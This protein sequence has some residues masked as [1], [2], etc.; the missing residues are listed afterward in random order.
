MDKLCLLL[1]QQAAADLRSY[2]HDPV[3][4]WFSHELKQRGKFPQGLDVVNLMIQNTYQA[5]GRTFLDA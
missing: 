2:Q 4:L 1:P 3:S 5:G